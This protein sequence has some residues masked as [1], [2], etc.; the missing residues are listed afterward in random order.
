MH[1]KG[2][3]VQIIPA[4]G[5]NA[6]FLADAPNP[7]G[8]WFIVSPLVCF[9]LVEH[10]DDGLV[11]EGFDGDWIVE[12]CENARN[13]HEYIHNGAINQDRKSRWNRDARRFA[14]NG[15]IRSGAELDEIIIAA[16]A[17]AEARGD[18]TGL[19]SA[20]KVAGASTGLTVAKLLAAK[21]KLDAEDQAKF[22]KPVK[23]KF[24]GPI[25]WNEKGLNLFFD[26]HNHAVRMETTADGAI[27]LVIDDAR[28]VFSD[29]QFLWFI[30]WL[31]LAFDKRNVTPDGAGH[32]PRDER[33]EK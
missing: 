19:P 3:I 5:W 20:Q 4:S 13:F 18:A 1:P 33:K 31:R 16:A 6:V 30:A 11:I 8:E 32:Q 24:N 2:K 9:G 26:E 14:A 25:L 29:E 15:K 28:L 17:E 10:P 27:V 23:S 22:S 21:Q 12:H 7:A